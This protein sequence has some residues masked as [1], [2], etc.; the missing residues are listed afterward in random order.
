M[1]LR[2]NK[3]GISTVIVFMLFL[4]LTVVVVANIYLWNYQMNQLDWERLQEEVKIANVTRANVTCSPWFV[5]QSEYTVN[6]GSHVSGTYE[7]TQ[8]ANDD[9]WETFQEETKPP[10]YRMDVNSTFT[11]DLSAYPLESVSTVEIQ[12]RYKASDNKGENW[13]LKAYNWSA[14]TY[15]YNGFN[16]TCHTPTKEWSSYAVNLTDQWRSYMRDDGVIYVKFCDEGNDSVQTTI[17]IDFLGV[18]TAANGSHFTFK[19]KG[20][21]TAHLVS[22]WIINSTVHQRYDLNLFVNSAETLQ[23]IRVD[24]RLPDGQYIVKV[25][26]ERGNIAVYSGS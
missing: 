10:K 12:L 19:N 1:G 16:S 13:Y 7:D 3:L 6:M 9:G 11:V 5:V 22:L 4:A 8:V 20:S 23:Y 21:L 25:V 17:D 26:T 15:S 18:R 14:N 2:K 24:I